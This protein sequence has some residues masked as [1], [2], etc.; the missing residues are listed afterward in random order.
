MGAAT[1]IIYAS[2][3]PSIKAVC[4]DS[5][6]SNFTNIIEDIASQKF[7]FPS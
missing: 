3:N 6:Y 5:P 2:R 4:L 1:T 7:S